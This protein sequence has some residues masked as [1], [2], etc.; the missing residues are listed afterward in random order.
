MRITSEDS[1]VNEP[2]FTRL[3]LAAKKIKRKLPWIGNPFLLVVL[4]LLLTH[5]IDVLASVVI[6]SVI[7]WII[8]FDTPPAAFDIAGCFLMG[9]MALAIYIISFPIWFWVCVKKCSNYFW[10]KS[11]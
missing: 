5:F 10:L 4:S 9:I 6:T 7:Q 3:E 8:P 1:K 11:Q 2:H